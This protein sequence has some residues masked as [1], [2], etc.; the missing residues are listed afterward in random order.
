MLRHSTTEH[1]EHHVV[2]GQVQ[3]FICLTSYQ[4][5]MFILEQYNETHFGAGHNTSL[6]DAFAPLEEA[7][8]VQRFQHSAM[9]DL[10]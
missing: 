3:Q 2:A 5:E 6:S 7:T 10:Y 9:S 8:V 1:L 4:I